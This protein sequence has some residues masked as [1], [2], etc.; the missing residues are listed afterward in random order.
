MR[1]VF[2]NHAHPELPH[3]SGMRFGYFAREMARRGHQVVLLTSPLPGSESGHPAQPELAERLQSALWT[4][5]LVVA[6]PPSRRLVLEMIR[7]NTVPTLVRRA[8]T[9]GQLL[10]H[11]GMFADWHKAVGDTIARLADN[12]RPH[13]VW[14][15]FGNTTNLMIT[16]Q[17]ARRAGCPWVA[18]IK[19]NWKTFV[20]RGF[21]RHIAWRLRD[22]AGWTTNSR[23]HRDIAS[24]WFGRQPAEVIY[25]GVAAEFFRRDASD[26]AERRQ[27]L[28]LGG[29]YDDTRLATYVGAVRE[30]LETL[31]PLERTTVTFAYAGTDGQRVRAALTRTRLP[32]EVRILG[33]Q[34]VAQLAETARASFANTYLFATFGFH[35]KLLELLVSGRPV[36]CYPGEHAESMELA[37]KSA[38]MFAACTTQRDLV[39]ALTSAWQQRNDRGES[40]GAPPWR[41][42]DF[43]VGLEQFLGR[44][45]RESTA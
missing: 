45:V 38:T 26:C 14:G 34:S 29:I 7:Q 37:S 10:V 27:L 32:C 1:L 18:D 16:R 20:P 30:W 31:P 6:V 23:H 35:H 15:T 25:S 39:D 42:S 17:L 5:P 8:L 36:I 19:D 12:F 24:R 4:Q 22:A 9:A 3:V 21:R 40:A 41:W 43:A 28:L 2:V 33:Y 44:F 11:G 13:V